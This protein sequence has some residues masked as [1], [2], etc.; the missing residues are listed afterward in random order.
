MPTAGYI[1][2]EGVRLHYIDSSGNERS[3]IGTITSATGDPGYLWIEG[4]NI[5][6]IDSG[7]DERYLPT[8]HIGTAPT[9]EGYLWIEGDWVHYS[10]ETDA[11]EKYWH[12][13]THGDSHG[14]LT[15]HYD[16][17]HTDWDDH[18]DYHVDWTDEGH[19]DYTDYVITIG[20]GDWTD[21]LDE[22]PYQ[23][24]DDG[25][26]QNTLHSDYDAHADSHTDSHTDEPALV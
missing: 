17:P 25:A 4:D 8:S 18:D 13:D 14:D 19:Q 23:D 6:Y 5:H 7:G 12:E 16:A 10:A 9:L 1:W 21:H 3:Q 20:H 26:H 15:Q 24:H 2:I 11:D 22:G